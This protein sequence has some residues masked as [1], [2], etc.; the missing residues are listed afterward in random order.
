LE[1]ARVL[2]QYAE[3]LPGREQLAVRIFA[4]ALESVALALTENAGLDPI[5]VL[6]ELRSKHEKGEK[7]AG[8]E[9]VSGKVQDMSKVGVFEPIAVKKQIIKSSTEAASLILKIDDVIAASK[10]KAPPTPPG[11]GPGGGYPDVGEY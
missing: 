6:S 2:K 8:I 10:M 5:D 9:V 11:G 1:M 7:W 4:E 3:T